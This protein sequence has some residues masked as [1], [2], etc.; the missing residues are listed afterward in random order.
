MVAIP[1]I[2]WKRFRATRSAVKMEARLPETSA[3]RSPLP[4]LSPSRRRAVK[5]KEWIQREKHLSED[6]DPRHDHLRF[7]RRPGDASLIPPERRSGR[8]VPRTDILVEGRPDQLLQ[9]ACRNDHDLP[10]YGKEPPAV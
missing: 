1:D 2:R 10:F 6:I 3:R 7:G 8:D 4:T 9:R 5:T